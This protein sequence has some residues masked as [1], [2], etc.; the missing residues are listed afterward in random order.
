MK[1][2]LDG[3]ISK[4][5]T[6]LSNSEKW[7]E[8]NKWLLTNQDKKLHDVKVKYIKNEIALLKEVVKRCK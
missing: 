3:E 7:R 2:W 4:R 5:H 1:D 8:D 6:Q